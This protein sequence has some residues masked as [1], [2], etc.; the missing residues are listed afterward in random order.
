[1]ENSLR[2]RSYKWGLYSESVTA[3]AID[4]T[5]LKCYGRDEWHQEKHRISAKRS[6]RKIHIAVDNAFYIQG[7]ALTDRLTSDEKVVD[8]LVANI[9]ISIK[10]VTAD[11]AYDKNHVYETLIKKIKDA[12]IIIPPDSD[13]VFNINNH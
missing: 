6:W 7:A 1:M 4:S 9:D 3:I 10:H 8:N 11:G 12:D 2:K 13:A 5:G